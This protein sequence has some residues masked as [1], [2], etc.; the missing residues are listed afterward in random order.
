MSRRHVQTKVRNIGL[1]PPIR[2]RTQSDK[3]SSCTATDESAPK[4]RYL[5]K[6]Y[7]S[8]YTTHCH[9]ETESKPHYL[10]PPVSARQQL[11]P[12]PNTAAITP[13]PKRPHSSAVV[14]V[15]RDSCPR[16]Q[17]KTA[18]RIR[19]VSPHSVVYAHQYPQAPMGELGFCS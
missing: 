17:S 6:R 4:C 15:Y 12:R 11:P 2:G 10:R 5:P 8:R 18:G 9:P 14:M 3:T 19:T 7:I 1:P 16:K 13:S